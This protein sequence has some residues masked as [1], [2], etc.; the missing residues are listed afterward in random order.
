MLEG[1]AIGQQQ[2]QRYSMHQENW[3]NGHH[4]QGHHLAA[5][6]PVM[7]PDYFMESPPQHSSQSH[8]MMMFH[9]NHAMH[10]DSWHAQ[11]MHQNGWQTEN[12]RPQHCIPS[13]IPEKYGRFNGAY[14]I[15]NAYPMV[16][17]GG[18]YPNM[19][20]SSEYESFSSIQQVPATKT[21]EAMGYEH[22]NW[23]GHYRQSYR[24]GFNTPGNGCQSIDWVSKAL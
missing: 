17:N 3:E 9:G 19:T 4:H 13:P 21:Y 15:S 12:M 2:Q 20:A 22:R 18:K 23:G 14:A 10:Q 8:Q 5:G 7:Q 11:N 24:D 16:S 6:M 1:Y